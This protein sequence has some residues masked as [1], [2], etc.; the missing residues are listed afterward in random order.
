MCD[1]HIMT[2]LVALCAS[3]GGAVYVLICPF[4]LLMRTI[5]EMF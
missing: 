3:K 4:K 5:R 1:D 2:M